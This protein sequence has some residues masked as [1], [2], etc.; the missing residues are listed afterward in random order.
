MCQSPSEARRAIQQG[1]V[2]LDGE[3][4]DDVAFEVPKPETEVLVQVGKKRVKR[5][6]P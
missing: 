3:V 4:K 2:R 5:L 6:T 1:G